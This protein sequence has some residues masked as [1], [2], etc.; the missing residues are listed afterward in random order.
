MRSGSAR[1]RPRWSALL[2]V[3]LVVHLCGCGTLL[4]PERHGRREGRVD[5]AV[6]LLDGA[7]LIFFIVPGLVA[8][9][10]DFYTGSVYL[11]GGGGRRAQVIPAPDGD[12]SDAAVRA[13]LRR[14]AVELPADVRPLALPCPDAETLAAWVASAP[15]RAPAAAMLGDF[16]SRG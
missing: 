6:L 2:G 11:P 9:G 4:Y 7:L 16:P 1:R 13:L 15:S 5:P 10:I 8:F 3:A 12:L 14:H